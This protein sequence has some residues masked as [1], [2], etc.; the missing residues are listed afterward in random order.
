[1]IL[2]AV[3]TERFRPDATAAQR[4][5][6]AR[7]L[8]STPFVL[9]VGSL[10]PDKRYDFLLDAWARAKGTLP[11]LLVG[12][13]GSQ[14]ERLRQRARELN[15]DARFLGQLSPDELLGAYNAALLVVHGCAV[16]TFGLSVLE[17]MACGRPVLGVRGGAVPEI[18]GDTGYLAPVGD[19]QSFD[20]LL[21]TALDDRRR[22]NLLGEAARRRVLEHFSLR[23][24]RRAYVAAIESS[25]GSC[26]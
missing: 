5:R 14:G 20:A 22:G 8:N 3:D 4:F 26:G 11:P 19:T 15:V 17:A 2:S 1:V 10:T 23:E 18:L 6:T 21:R 9:A 7:S 16:E 24:M 25:V 13:E 12:G